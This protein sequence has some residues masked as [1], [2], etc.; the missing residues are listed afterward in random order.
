V[1]FQPFL[2]VHLAQVRKKLMIHY[3][4][5]NVI[6][7]VASTI[8]AKIYHLSNLY[9]CLESLIIFALVPNAMGKKVDMTPTTGLVKCF[10][11]A[12]NFLPRQEN[13]NLH[14]WDQL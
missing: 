11:R 3:T 5:I 7:A 1:S 2:L 4:S 14:L 13:K 10:P 12:T 6:Y 8:T 9:L